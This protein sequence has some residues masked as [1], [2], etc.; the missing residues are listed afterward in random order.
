MVGKVE[1][2]FYF[3]LFGQ[4]AVPTDP[5]LLGNSNYIQSLKYV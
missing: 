3:F 2:Y 5:D 1:T 4:P